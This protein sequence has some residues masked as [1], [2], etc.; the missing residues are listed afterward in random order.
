MFY[1]RK[2]RSSPTFEQI[3]A[4]QY[5]LRTKHLNSGHVRNLRDAW[6]SHRNHAN[7]RN[8]SRAKK[9]SSRAKIGPQLDH[10]A[11]DYV[12]IKSIRRFS[13]VRYVKKI[14]FSLSGVVILSSMKVAK[15]IQN[16][17]KKTVWINVVKKTKI[18]TFIF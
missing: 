3:F 2:K 4:Q 15:L 14:N 17:I 18:S 11:L 10:A 13:H 12:F 6:Q 1:K 7:H 8:Y 5:F 9:I 16:F